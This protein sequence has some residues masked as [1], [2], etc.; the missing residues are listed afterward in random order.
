[1][2][3][4]AAGLARTFRVSC[5]IEEDWLDVSFAHDASRPLSSFAGIFVPGW[6]SARKAKGGEVTADLHAFL[7]REPDAEVGA[8]HRK[9]M[10]VILTSEEE[11]DAWPRSPLPEA[12]GRQRPL[13]DGAL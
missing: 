13:P 9:A 1:M 10:P 2:T 3:D 7:S 12:S 5:H 8:I 4:L 11:R 6:K